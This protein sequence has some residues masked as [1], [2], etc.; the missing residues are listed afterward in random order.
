METSE[1]QA[2]LVN[3]L[4]LEEVHVMSKD[5]KHFQVIAIGEMFKELSRIKK[6]QVIYEPL[7]KYIQDNK[8]HALS[9]K[10]YTPD[11]WRL[12]QKSNIFK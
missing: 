2:V 4:A 3:A 7:M 5:G 11:E 8:I 6:Q 12:N 9:I 10:T 1:V